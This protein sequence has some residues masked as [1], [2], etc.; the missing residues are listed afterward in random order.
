[1][2]DPYMQAEDDLVDALNDGQI[3]E[4][5]FRAEMRALRDELQAEAEQAAQDAYDEV[6]G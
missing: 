1:M 3:T 2:K 4:A 5:E 6:M